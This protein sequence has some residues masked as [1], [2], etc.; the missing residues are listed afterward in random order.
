MT[1]AQMYTAMGSDYNALLE[2]LGSERLIKKLLVKYPE[3]K[4]FDILAEGMAE[5]DYEKAFTGVHTVKG[6]SSNMGFDKLFEVSAK[7]SDSLKHHQYEG[8]EEMYEDVKKAQEEVL[9]L[10]AQTEV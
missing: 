2:R 5:K 7:L 6:L 8:V 1:V 4:N 9:S 10:I 3:D